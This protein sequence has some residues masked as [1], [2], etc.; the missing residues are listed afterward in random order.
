M[1]KKNRNIQKKIAQMVAAGKPLGGLLAGMMASAA[2]A[3]STT[4]AVPRR[5]AGVP[6]PGKP[7][8]VAVETN[9]CRQVKEGHVR[10]RKYPARPMKLTTM[11]EPPA[12]PVKTPE[13]PKTQKKKS[14]TQK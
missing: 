8:P 14:S 5:L 11:G 12:R 9:Q 1:N 4:N 2:I 3:G 10:G 6:V 13:A 7:A